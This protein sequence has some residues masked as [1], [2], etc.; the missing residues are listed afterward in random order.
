MEEIIG[1]KELQ[2]GQPVNVKGK[3][4]E[5]G[6]FLA[7][8]ISVRA[9]Q[10]GVAMVGEIQ[11]LDPETGTLRLLNQD[12][13]LPNDFAVR[14]AERYDIGFENLKIGSVVKLKGRYS[15]VEGFVPDSL[16]MKETFGF[17]VDKLIGQIDLIDGERRMLK[18]IG[19]PVLVNHKTMIEG[20]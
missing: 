12:F 5:D 19:F 4:L 13:I 9:Y 10:N 1:F 20:F 16:K 14:D 8:E 15:P 3:L 7:L 18:M 6:S 2:V 17:N 11:K